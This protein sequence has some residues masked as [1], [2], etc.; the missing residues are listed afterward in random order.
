MA[1][2]ASLA[3]AG[4]TLANS[5]HAEDCGALRRLTLPHAIVT[6]AAVVSPDQLT[7]PLSGL[8]APRA[9]YCRV[10]ATARPTADSEIGFEVWIPLGAAWNGKYEQV[11]NGGLAGQIPYPA[12][13]H[14]LSLGYAVAGTDDGHRT[15]EVTDARWAA[16]HPEKVK[17]FGWRALQE[18]AIGAT[19]IVRALKADAPLHSYFVG[20]SDGGRE[21]L[22]LAERFPTTFD[23]IIAGAPGYATIRLVTNGALLLQQYEKPGRAL[24]V[25]K[26]PLLQ[27]FALRS[28]AAGAR[29][30]KDPRQCHIDP[31][32]LRC[33]GEETTSCLTEGQVETVRMLYQGRQ[34]P[35]TG[36]IQFGLMPGAEAVAGGWD[37]WLGIDP[38]TPGKRPLVLSF[39]W[40]YIAYMVKND[41]NFDIA[42]LST[43]DLAHG[44]ALYSPDIDT[45]TADLSAFQAHGGKLIQYHGWNDPAISPGYSLDYR[46]RLL[47]SLGRVDDFY[48]LYMVPGML[49][50]NGGDAPTQVDWQ[51]VLESWVEKNIAPSSL[52]ATGA[53]GTQELSPE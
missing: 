15:D 13:V 53:G 12:M 28:C 7:A 4:L 29:Y 17:D 25:A 32:A 27:S 5:V 23:G 49:H 34:D 39:A 22:M 45:Q 26:L 9:A 2:A 11:G 30:I 14:P 37:R 31:S 6:D 50:C 24:P 8:P 21:A 51:V 10:Q 3:C 47:S 48:R 52:T 36:E 35:A 38:A 33:I 41:P 16:G 20:C 1:A 46:R 44:Y 43:E 18:T 19:A 42:A 40:N